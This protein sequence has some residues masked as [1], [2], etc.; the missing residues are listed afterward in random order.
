MLAGTVAA[1][2]AGG[3][4]MPFC[5]G[6][7]D[8]VDGKP[9]EDERPVHKASGFKTGLE[10]KEAASLLGLTVAEFV[11]LNGGAH[12]AG[13]ISGGVAALEEIEKGSIKPA[14]TNQYF[15]QLLAAEDTALVSWDIVVM[16]EAELLAAVHSFAEDEQYFLDTFA[17]A[18]TKL[19]N[20]D[21]FDGPVKNLCDAPGAIAPH[22][23]SVSGLVSEQPAA[24]R[25]TRA[26]AHAAWIAAPL[27]A[28][29]G[30]AG[31]SKV[32]AGAARSFAPLGEMS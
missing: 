8:A 21:R 18:W 5:P 19:A 26:T 25:A 20:A 24:P 17:A 30:L 15:A 22:H 9:L 1:E 32:K 2:Q 13:Y 4:P 14:L 29:V 3:N 7:V 28:V 6:R 11:A 23:T 12:S 27:V 16:R 10:F 31:Y